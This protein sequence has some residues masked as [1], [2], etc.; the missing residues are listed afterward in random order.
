MNDPITT[1]EPPTTASWK[2]HQISRIP[3]FKG[4][5]EVYLNVLKHYIP[6]GVVQRFGGRVLKS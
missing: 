3:G 2:K 4:D 1:R 6:D 5:L